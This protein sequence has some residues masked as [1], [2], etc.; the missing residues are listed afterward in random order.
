MMT[1]SSLERL[2]DAEI[3]D[4]QAQRIDANEGVRHG[5]AQHEI[6]LGDVRLPLPLLPRARREIRLLEIDRR[7]ERRLVQLAKRDVLDL[8]V[9]LVADGF[10][11]K[12]SMVRFWSFWAIVASAR[13]G[14]RKNS[15]SG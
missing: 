13:A 14:S 3:G 5:V 4:L 8:D 2:V 15:E 10:V 1:T 6:D 12:P 7:L 9:D 11:R